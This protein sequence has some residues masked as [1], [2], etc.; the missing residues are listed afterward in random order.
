MAAIPKVSFTD[1]KTL[2]M[3][4]A[5]HH[6]MNLQTANNGVT[7]LMIALESKN[8]PFISEAVGQNGVLKDIV[9]FSL[10]DKH[11]RNYVYYAVSLHIQCH[12]T[13]EPEKEKD[14][15]LLKVI[16]GNNT[17]AREVDSEG[18]TPL[19]LA[20]A[21]KRLDIVKFIVSRCPN[22]LEHN[23]KS[24]ASLLHVAAEVG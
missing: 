3:K 10:S 19:H 11:N 4:A 18:R 20:V 15:V 5:I 12:P 6:K 2:Y 13:T 1:Q 22:A 14:G 16:N 8:L 17:G 9:N 23:S 21:S 24:V 7:P